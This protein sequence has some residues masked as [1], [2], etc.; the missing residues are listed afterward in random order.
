[1][2][3]EESLVFSYL[4]RIKKCKIIQNNWFPC[5]EE[6][7]ILSRKADD[8][9]NTSKNYFKNKYRIEL[10]ENISAFNEIDAGN[11]INAFGISF[12]E[13]YT[14]KI[15]GVSCNVK[16]HGDDD[17][18][19][20]RIIESIILTG[21]YIVSCFNKIEGNIIYLGANEDFNVIK[22]LGM[23][24]PDIKEIFN[25][26]K[27]DFNIKIYINEEFENEVLKKLMSHLD[28]A[29]IC[30]NE[31]YLKFLKFNNHLNGKVSNQ[32]D[33]K[34]EVVVTKEIE[35]PEEKNDNIQE[36]I[37]EKSDDEKINIKPQ[38]KKI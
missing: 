23:Y 28:S 16:E 2:D 6:W 14:E 35:E 5:M 29:E 18:H 38:L 34:I 25:Q 20:K 36:V 11:K 17:E 1:M 15:Y 4:R 9:M 37:E 32:A 27:C 13:D 26:M 33:E 8:I 24:Y 30:R 21:I 31:E 7:S 10:F 19:I 12:N 22:K 3:F